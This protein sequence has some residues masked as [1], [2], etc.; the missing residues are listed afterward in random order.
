[1]G[2]QHFPL[3]S[4]VTSNIPASSSCHVLWDLVAIVE[5]MT[6]SGL[7]TCRWLWPLATV[8]GEK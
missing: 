1:M 7:R 5:M 6:S 2:D 3:G 8:L 4:I